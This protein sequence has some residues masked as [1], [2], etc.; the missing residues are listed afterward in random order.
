M[1]VT[2]MISGGFDPLHVGH[3]EL[4]ETAATYGKVVAVVMSDEWLIRKKGYCF[5][6]WAERKRIVCSIRQVWWTYSCLNDD[7]D[8]ALALALLRPKYFLNGGDRT[9]PDPK[10]DAICKEIGCEQVFS[11]D[12]IQ[13]SSQ[14]ARQANIEIMKNNLQKVHG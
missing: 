3:L 4:I 1:T 11:G 14:L 10:E 9:E 12:K 13:S 7:A 6:P 5:M 8:V 2:V